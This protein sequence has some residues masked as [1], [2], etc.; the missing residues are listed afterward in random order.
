MDKVVTITTGVAFKACENLSVFAGKKVSFSCYS[1]TKLMQFIQISL[2]VSH[3]RYCL[4]YSL[5][6]PYTH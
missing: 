2:Y 3:A 4:F 1:T 6:K 5:N